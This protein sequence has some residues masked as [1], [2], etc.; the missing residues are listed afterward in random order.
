ME[1]KANWMS[2]QSFCKSYGMDLLGLASEHEEKYFLAKCKEAKNSFEELSHI[3]GVS[4]NCADN[5]KWYW[6]WSNEKI[7]I[8]LKFRPESQKAKGRNCLQLI[9]DEYGDFSYSRT[10]C[11]SPEL[12]KFV[13]QKIILNKLDGMS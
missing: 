12:Q 7:Q 13:C 9:K 4:N 1:F 10:N 5:D 11:N 2:A 8:D 3:G 6:I